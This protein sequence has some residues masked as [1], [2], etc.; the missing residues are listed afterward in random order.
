[1]PCYFNIFLKAIFTILSVF[2]IVLKIY[3]RKFEKCNT[4]IIKLTFFQK[5]INIQLANI[6]IILQTRKN[7]MIFLVGMS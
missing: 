1:M 2:P 3:I 6:H 7:T 5:I 4:Q